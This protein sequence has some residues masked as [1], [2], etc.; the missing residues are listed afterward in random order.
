MNSSLKYNMRDNSDIKQ[1]KESGCQ[2]GQEIINNLNNYINNHPECT[3][4]QNSLMSSLIAGVYDSDITIADLLKHGDF[5][6]GTFNQLDGEL[7]AFD[8]NVFQLRS[9]GSAR[10][11]LNSQKSPFAV[12]T[13]FNCDIEHHFS[14]GASQKEIH[15]VINQYVPSDNLFCAIRIEGEFELVKTRTVPRQEPPYLPMLEAIENQP[16]FNFHNETGTIAGFRSPQFTQGINVAG[17]HEHYI[18]QQRQGGG[19]VLDYYLKKGT[20]QIGIISRLTIDLPSQSAFLQANLM[21]DNLHQAIE[22]AEN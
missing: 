18:N 7:V 5:G 13:F 12:M 11:A 14:Y 8:S 9:D 20:L 6:L 1:N 16:I 19:H 3:V 17:F 4:Y 10:K 15:N 2:C 22:K 21:P